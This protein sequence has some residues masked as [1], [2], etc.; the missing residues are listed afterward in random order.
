MKN[1]SLMIFVAVVIALAC[2]CQKNEAPS[3][4]DSV[5]GELQK[6]QK[7]AG[8]DDPNAAPRQRSRTTK[9]PG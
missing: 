5:A 4:A 3:G 9:I 7:E 2:G 6:A 8:V 1:W